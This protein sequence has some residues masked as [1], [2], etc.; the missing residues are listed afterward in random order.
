VVRSF[1]QGP[2]VEAEVELELRG[3]SLAVLQELGETIRQRLGERPEVLH[4]QATLERGEPKLWVDVDED[5]A[6]LAGLTLRDVAAQLES[7]LEGR[8]GGSVRESFEELPVRVRTRNEARADRAGV[9]ETQLLGT[10]AGTDWIPLAALGDLELRPEIGGITRCDGERCNQ[11]RAYLR[12]GALPIDVTNAVLV[13]LEESDFRL[14]AGYSL[15]V[16]GDSEEQAAAV[17]SLLTYAPVLGVLMV[18]TVVLSFRSAA[19]AALLFAVA[20]LS[21]GVGL[22]ATWVSGFPFSFNS[23]LGTAGLIGVA[24]N[25]SIV[26]LAAIRAEPRAREGQIDAVVEVVLACSRHVLSTTL[27]TIGGFLPLLLFVGGDFWPPLAIVLAGGVAGAT[28]LATV[29][30]PAGYVTIQRG[31]GLGE[32]R[33]AARPTPATA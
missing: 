5:E 19:L 6:R 30:V 31:V 9:A 14:P 24:L 21:A 15:R 3:P 20:G 26:V 22:L 12:A 29:F 1:A 27:T 33:L 8:Q 25:D 28:V 10:A 23:I 4:T 32:A 7:R 17:S 2:P 11:V 13:S 18:A 16:G